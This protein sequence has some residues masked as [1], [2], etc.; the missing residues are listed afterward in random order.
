MHDLRWHWTT[1]L[2]RTM[3]KLKSYFVFLCSMNEVFNI[4]TRPTIFEKKNKTKTKNK[5]IKYLSSLTFQSL[6]HPFFPRSFLL[7]DLNLKIWK[8][9]SSLNSFEFRKKKKWMNVGWK[10]ESIAWNVY[11]LFINIK[12]FRSRI[13]ILINHSS[14]CWLLDILF[15]HCLLDWIVFLRSNYASN[16]KN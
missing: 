4:I 9:E 13:L 2:H 7:M 3:L 16:A 15:I 1:S 8:K 11:Q 10:M 5:I 12:T 14:V 6:L